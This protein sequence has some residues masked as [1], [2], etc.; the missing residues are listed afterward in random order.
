MYMNKSRWLCCLIALSILAAIPST[1]LA[2]FSGS[3]RT[4]LP[5]R[6][7]LSGNSHTDLYEYLDLELS[8]AGMKGVS[9]HFG[10]WGRVSLGE[11]TY[12]DSTRGEF[13]YGYLDYRHEK[14]NSVV[15]AGRMYV[16]EGVAAYE[17]VDGLQFTSD[18]LHGFSVALYGGV[19]VATDD[20]GRD[21]DFIYGGRFAQGKPGLYEL[22]IS[23]LKQ[24]NDDS[25][26]REEI[27]IDLFLMPHPAVSLSGHSFYND[28]DSE[29]MEHDY[30]LVLGPFS[31]WTVTG[32]A[33]QIDYDSYFRSPGLASFSFP[34][35]EAGEELQLLSGELAWAFRPGFAVAAFY[36]SYGYEVEEDADSYGARFSWS[37]ASAAAGLYY[38][39]MDGGTD[40]LRYSEYRGYVKKHFGNIDVTFDALDVVYDERINGVKDAYA[41]VLALGYNVNDR[42]RLSADG[43]YGEN[44]LFDEEVKG[45]LKILWRFSADFGKKGGGS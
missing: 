42:L 23:Y 14:A 15:R 11:D 44:P 31:G 26:F 17:S 6:E 25:D 34:L 18:L 2:S 43:E 39:R 16:S 1:V 5:A 40:E 24:E 9:F 19:P 30:Y 29:W 32:Q 37:G 10:G 45:M 28:L 21:G 35:L 7:S 38:T 12:G 41:L 22:G 13:Q 4:Y 27:G 3:S 36:R 8:G 20:D 33:S